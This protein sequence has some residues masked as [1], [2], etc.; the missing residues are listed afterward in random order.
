MA[1][2]ALAVKAGWT[3]RPP[4]HAYLQHAGWRAVWLHI[5]DLGDVRPSDEFAALA[6]MSPIEE[7]FMQAVSPSIEDS[8]PQP[9]SGRVRA[10]PQEFG[11][12]MASAAFELAFQGPPSLLQALQDD[13]P[14]ITHINPPELLVAAAFP[15]YQLIGELKPGPAAA[16]RDAFSRELAA[17]LLAV[18]EFLELSAPDPDEL[19]GWILGRLKEYSLWMP[20]AGTE[21]AAPAFGRTVSEALT[22][23]P[24]PV[25]A[26]NVAVRYSIVRRQFSEAVQSY[27][28]VV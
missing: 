13:C 4:L 7:G 17:A 1:V 14:D 26:T 8:R 16:L 11:S 3:A 12:A 9:G 20:D 5:L 25:F 2:M 15:L 27:E 24:D 18:P 23:R 28:I 19:D 21:M 22:G 10:T 6:A